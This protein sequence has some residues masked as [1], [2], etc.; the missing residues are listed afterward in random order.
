MHNTAA[1]SQPLP[2][3]TWLQ[4]GSQ[5][6]YLIARCDACGVVVEREMQDIEDDAVLDAIGSEL[7][8]AGGCSHAE[9]GPGSGLRPAL[10][11]QR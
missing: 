6:F 8:G 9:C 2:R 4:V 10:R 3:V 11:V 7:L 5:T 1:R